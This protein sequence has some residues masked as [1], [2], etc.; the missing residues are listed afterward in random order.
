MYKFTHAIILSREEYDTIMEVDG[1]LDWDK[2]LDDDYI[3]HA[4]ISEH[5]G[6]VIY[7]SIGQ[8]TETSILG[9][10]EG[11]MVGIDYIVPT[12]EYEEHRAIYIYDKEDCVSPKSLLMRDDIL[13]KYKKGKAVWQD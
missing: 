5:N 11:F 1:R 6:Y 12:V 7:I 4:L 9:Q 13:N 10:I 8:T 3:T 2:I